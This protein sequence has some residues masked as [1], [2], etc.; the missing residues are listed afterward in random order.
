M[1]IEIGDLM[2]RFLQK[3]IP[4]GMYNAKTR[5]SQSDMNMVTVYS[6]KTTKLNYCISYWYIIYIIKHQITA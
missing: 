1:S 5:R 3:Y 6:L 4:M 2:S